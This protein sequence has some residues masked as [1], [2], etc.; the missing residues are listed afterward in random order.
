M[1]SAFTGRSPRCLRYSAKA[2]AA[3]SFDMSVSI[4]ITPLSVSTR[5]MFDR[6][7]PRTW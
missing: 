4:T 7:S 2:A 3:V 1:I 6:S 5:D